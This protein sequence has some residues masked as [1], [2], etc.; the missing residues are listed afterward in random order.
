MSRWLPS[1]LDR[2]AWT[3]PECPRQAQ[4][5]LHGEQKRRPSY[6]TLPDDAVIAEILEHRGLR[7]AQVF[8]GVF[9]GMCSPAGTER[10]KRGLTRPSS[11][12]ESMNRKLRTSTKSICRSWN[13]KPS[14]SSDRASRAEDRRYRPRPYA[15]IAKAVPIVVHAASGAGTGNP[16][17]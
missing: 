7:R 1:V 14:T 16:G 10:E 17:K 9:L 6:M 13:T 3:L 12:V 11:I 15:S 2:T 4:R 5:E 8:D